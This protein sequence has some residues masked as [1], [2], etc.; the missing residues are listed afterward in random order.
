MGIE[1]EGITPEMIELEREKLK[2]VRTLREFKKMR[3]GQA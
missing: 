1:K 3:K 2:M